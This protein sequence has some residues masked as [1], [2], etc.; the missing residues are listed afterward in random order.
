MAPAPY[1]RQLV[2]DAER[3]SLEAAL[4][5]AFPVVEKLPADLIELASRLNSSQKLMRG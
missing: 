2:E 1:F 5:D 4:R 3:L